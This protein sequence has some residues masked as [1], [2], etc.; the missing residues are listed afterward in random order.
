MN[1]FINEKQDKS[2][3]SNFTYYETL[4]CVVEH[5]PDVLAGIEERHK[6]DL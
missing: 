5:I 1:E 4:A 3:C 6:T 2:T